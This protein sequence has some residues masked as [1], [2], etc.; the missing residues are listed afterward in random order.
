MLINKDYDHSHSVRVA[1]SNPEG[2]SSF[3]GPVTMITFGKA[4][5]QWHPNRKQGFADPNNPPVTTTLKVDP[6][7]S[8]ELPAASV[9]VLRGNLR[10]RGQP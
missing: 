5:Y 2:N 7:T 3:S 1:F 9:T 10:D 6:N 8:Y 4:Q